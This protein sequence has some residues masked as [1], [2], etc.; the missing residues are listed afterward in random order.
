[1]TYVLEW[2]ATYLD[3]LW[4]YEVIRNSLDFGP[5]D[6]V[7]EVGTG[8]GYISFK[9]RKKVREVVAIDISSPTIYVLNIYAKHK[10]N[11]RFEN[12]D[13]YDEKFAAAYRG[14][15]T[16]AV[17]TDVVEHVSD[18]GGMI[19]AISEV[20]TDEGSMSILFPNVSTHGR[21]HF[22]TREEVSR[23]FT[24]ASLTPRISTISPSPFY[25]KGTGFVKRIIKLFAKI[26]KDVEEWRDV[27]QFHQT[28]TFRA[29]ANPKFYHW[30]YKL[31]CEILMI[32]MR[33]T[34]L[35]ILDQEGDV[36]EARILVTATKSSDNG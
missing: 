17:S 10:S 4:F 6:S 29:I 18:P 1:M 21:K 20:L 5:D 7:L 28:A 3:T 15:F 24:N 12:Y 23:L 36:N 25:H 2:P 33:T 22:S 19:A 11:L 27:D 26:D 30:W 32:I 34:P 31:G 14:Y 13:V 35:F 16:K 9:L 8:T